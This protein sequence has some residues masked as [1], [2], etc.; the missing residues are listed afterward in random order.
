MVKEA[1][2]EVLFK[3]QG[4]P[5]FHDCGMDGIADLVFRAYKVISKLC[6]QQCWKTGI[7][8]LC[9]AVAAPHRK[10]YALSASKPTRRTDSTNLR[11]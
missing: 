4:V 2:A 7:P 11:S 3:M 6:A 8:A 9:S 10:S 5:N 1:L